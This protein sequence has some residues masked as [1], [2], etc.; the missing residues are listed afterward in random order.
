MKNKA[1]LKRFL[2][3]TLIAAVGILILFS[4]LNVIEYRV[5]TEHF[6]RKL[7]AVVAAV[8]EAYP[9]VTEEE[10]IELLNEENAG[11]PAFFAKYGI[12]VDRDAILTENERAHVRLLILNAALLVAAVAFL[13]FL[14]VWYDRQKAKDIADI[15]RTIEQIN[16]R[17]FELDIDSISEDELSILKNEIYKTTV[18]LREAADRSHADKR[19]LKKSLEDISHQLKTPLTSILVML[20]NLID[21]PEMD[22]AVREDFIRS[23][24][25]ETVNINFFV[26]AIL[27]LSRFDSNTIRFN[28]EKTELR[29]LIGD[30]VRNVSALCDLRSITVEVD[31]EGDAEIVC[32]RKW[33]VEAITNILKNGIDHSPDGG[34]VV[35]RCSRNTA[36][37]MIEIIDFGEGI[38]ETDLPHVFERFYKGENASHDSIGIGL[39]LA[40][41]IIEEENG[42]VSVDSTSSGTRFRIQYFT[43]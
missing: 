6:N 3:R 5:Y 24:K 7:S 11:D 31:G 15:T 27:K 16:K 42:T 34:K 33:Q 9:A 18:T 41:S 4:A 22:P 19:K 23:I 21:D 30:A 17:N 36:Y 25:R 38:S 10:L 12:D 40:K 13:V 28:K 14:F 20:D 8:R 37:T 35:V 26:Q 1:K 39:A 29:R 2:F 32:D 43:L